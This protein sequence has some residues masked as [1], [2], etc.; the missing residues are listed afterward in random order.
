M[1]TID[2]F[3][4]KLLDFLRAYS[5]AGQLSFTVRGS[6]YAN[7]HTG[8]D[9]YYA[10]QTQVLRALGLGYSFD[11]GTRQLAVNAEIG[12]KVFN[13]FE[14]S[15][16]EG[17]GEPTHRLPPHLRQAVDE[18]VQPQD[19]PLVHRLRR[20]QGVQV[21]QAARGGAGTRAALCARLGGSLGR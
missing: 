11:P 5:A 2:E 6:A 12:I 19:G 14:E 17:E 16:V 4:P 3:F 20:L 15:A 10:E 7:A 1:P 9:D 21:H 8:A 18:E 13:L